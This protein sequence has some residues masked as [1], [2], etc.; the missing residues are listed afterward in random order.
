MYKRQRY[1]YL[2]AWLNPVPES[3]WSR[4]TAEAIRALVPMFPLSRDGLI[5][6]VNTLRGVPRS[7][8]VG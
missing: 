4:S 2:L 8:K 1:T 6:T 3:R 5:D 7:L